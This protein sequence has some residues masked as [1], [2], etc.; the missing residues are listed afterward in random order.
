MNRAELSACIA[1]E[2]SQSKAGADDAVTAVFSTIYDALATGETDRIDG[3]GTFSMTSRPARQSRNPRERARTSP[4]T[5]RRCL[6]SRPARPS[7]RPST[8]GF[9]ERE[10]RCRT[11]P[12][13]RR[14]NGGGKSSGSVSAP[15][16]RCRSPEPPIR[17][18]DRSRRSQ[19]PR[20]FVANVAVRRRRNFGDSSVVR[21]PAPRRADVESPRVRVRYNARC[22]SPTATPLRTAAHTQYREALPI[23]FHPLSDAIQTPVSVSRR[24]SPRPAD[25]GCPVVREDPPTVTSTIVT[26][27]RSASPHPRWPRGPCRRVS[28]THRTSSQHHCLPVRFD[29]IVVVDHSLARLSR[30]AIAGEMTPPSATRACD[31]Q[32][33]GTGS[34]AVFVYATSHF[35]PSA[36]QPPDHH[37]PRRTNW[38][39]SKIK[40]DTSAAPATVGLAMSGHPPV[41]HSLSGR[42]PTAERTKSLGGRRSPHPTDR[43]LPRISYNNDRHGCTIVDQVPSTFAC[44]YLH[45]Q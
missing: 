1:T 26:I 40:P 20:A 11:V 25:S 45:Q 13:H 19:I 41:S 3:F 30:R 42:N 31:M 27:G 15:P 8:G 37:E 21:T 9:G 39:H 36:G 5:P 14:M 6:S 10:S 24:R 17:R 33:R 16:V 7:A 29:P 12:I 4:P 44:T 43:P 22:E 34:D 35:G 38:R 23:C 32:S 18:P 28:R 2:T